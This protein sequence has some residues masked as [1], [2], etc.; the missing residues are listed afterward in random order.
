MTWSHPRPMAHR[1]VTELAVQITFTEPG[2][3][4]YVFT[5]DWTRPYPRLSWPARPA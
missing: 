1:S 2:G 4:A 5:F 3:Q